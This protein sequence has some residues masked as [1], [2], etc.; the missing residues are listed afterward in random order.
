MKKQFSSEF[1]DFY[2]DLLCAVSI[3]I[4]ARGLQKECASVLGVDSTY[5]NKVLRGVVACNSRLFVQILH[6]AGFDIVKGVKTEKGT[7]YSGI[8]L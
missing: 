8:V 3:Q 4:Y 6:Y 5:L 1:L 7:L 2:N